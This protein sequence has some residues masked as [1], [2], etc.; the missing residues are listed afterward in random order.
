MD[1][2]S[3]KEIPQIVKDWP[4]VEK[5]LSHANAENARGTPRG[6]VFVW[7]TMIE[8]LLGNI[9]QEFLIDHSVSKKLVWEDAHSS[10][11]SFSGRA[12]LCFALGLISRR[13]LSVCDGVR[14][15][16]NVAAHTRDFDLD[17][18]SVS[19]QVLKSLRALYDLDHSK[20]YEWEAGDLTFLIRHFYASSCASLALR[21]AERR[22]EMSTERRIER[23]DE[24]KN[25]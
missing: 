13:D 10:L 24:P 4:E 8:M 23:E 7:S 21:L 18:P 12:K 17:D 11:A 20:L 25:A 3:G 19:K 22:A 9:L 14:K 15:V 5:F 16:R 2:D 1:E 6:I